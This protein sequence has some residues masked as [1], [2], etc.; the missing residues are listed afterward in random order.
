M[1]RTSLDAFFKGVKRSNFRVVFWD[2]VEE[3]YGEGPPA[4]I[5]RFRREPSTEFMLEHD[6][7]LT[8][9]EAYMDGIIDFE[10]SID[11]LIRMVE[12]NKAHFIKNSRMGKTLSVLHGLLHLR[13]ADT[14]RRQKQNIQHHYD[15]G[16]DFFSLW[17][18]PTLCYSCAYFA[19]PE[20]SLH[21]AQLMKV[22]H[23]LKK[24]DLHPGERLLDIG[25]GWGWLITRAAQQ[26][27]VKTLGITLSEEQYRGTKERISRMRLSDQVEVRLMNYLDLDE[28]VDSFHKIVSVGM[29]EH[30]GQR[31]LRRYMDK[32]S[33][34]L[35]EGGVSLLHSITTSKE[36]AP[37]A[38]WGQKYIFP[39]GY[40]PSLRETVWMLPDFDFNLIHME[41]LRLHY[42][43]TLE[44]WYANFFA[45]MDEIREKF[46]ER[47]VRMWSLYLRG[48]AAYF[49]TGSLDVCQLLFT[50]GIN[51][52]FPITFDHIYRG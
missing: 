41:S 8:F 22:D 36:Q 38:S 3:T 10:G 49:R 4:A 33:R 25:S 32:V 27:G 2:G 43:K 21:E 13:G 30:V 50:K 16:N 18:D 34:L 31:F 39:G 1:T 46:G 42:A 7:V 52:I 51:N 19:K 28:K 40:I 47:F 5:I 12:E 20:L 23:I 11:E 6:A 29:F 17:L 44:C 35:V 15:L 24:L 37:Q 26:Y 14:R 48:S 45:H 9:G